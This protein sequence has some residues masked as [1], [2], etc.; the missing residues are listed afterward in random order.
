MPYERRKREIGKSAWHFGKRLR[1]MLVSVFSFTDLPIM[2]LLWVG[3][4]GSALSILASLIVFAAWLG[5][6][7]EVPG[8]TPQMLAILFFGSLLLLTQGLLGSYLWRAFE[9]TKQRP[10]TI[11][12]HHHVFSTE[13][14]KS[15][16]NPVDIEVDHA[17]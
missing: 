2:V 10:L 13:H 14:G 15:V 1:Y 7:I 3:G 8:Y 5:G 12:Q 17:S 6:A 4:T 16:E 11:I 9:N